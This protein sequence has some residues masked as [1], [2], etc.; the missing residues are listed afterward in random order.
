MAAET[1]KCGT[2][3]ALGS[4]WAQF[5]WM[6]CHSCDACTARFGGWRE[7][8]ESP[9]RPLSILFPRFLKVKS[10]TVDDLF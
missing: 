10:L 4:R 1:G 8:D 2:C 9:E 5:P 6:H 7:E 3:G